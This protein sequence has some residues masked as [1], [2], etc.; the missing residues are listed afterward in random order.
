VWYRT[1]TTYVVSTYSTTSIEDIARIATQPL[2][3][4]LY[5]QSDRGFTKDVVQRIEAAGCRTLCVTVD[6][7]YPAFVTV[8][9]VPDSS[10]RQI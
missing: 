6:S 3:F 10:C 2:W 1:D 9:N 5:I 7:Q 4:Q 8:S